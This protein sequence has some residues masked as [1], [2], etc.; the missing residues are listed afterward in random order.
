MSATRR[1]CANW[2]L[3]VMFTSMCL[4]VC[5]TVVA[6]AGVTAACCTEVGHGDPTISNCCRTGESSATQDLPDTVRPSGLAAMDVCP[7]WAEPC[8]QRRAA[9][10]GVPFLSRNAQAVLST[11]LI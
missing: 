5:A 4:G 1:H 2:L 10:P 11:F 7:S 8:R 6:A 3:L 9:L